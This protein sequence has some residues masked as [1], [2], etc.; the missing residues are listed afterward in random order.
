MK[1]IHKECKFNRNKIKMKRK[2]TISYFFNIKRRDVV[3]FIKFNV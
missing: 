2:G 1:Y 3:Y